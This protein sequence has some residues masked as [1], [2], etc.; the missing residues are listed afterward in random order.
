[1][2]DKARVVKVYCDGGSRGNPGPAASG[3]VVTDGRDRVLA[4]FCQYLGIATNNFA[5]YQAVV[6]ALQKLAE[7][8]I[9]QADFYLDSELV[10][11]QLNGVY[12]IKHDGLKPLYHQI[13]EL[14]TGK[15]FTFT[16]VLR[17]DNK[18]A[19]AQVNKCLDAH[20]KS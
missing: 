7:L 17:A 1:M 19:D 18:L 10:V 4:E 9:T 20:T 6:L 5:E 3:V 15:Q 2:P 11:R 16:H 8:K 13:Q 12:R 14:K